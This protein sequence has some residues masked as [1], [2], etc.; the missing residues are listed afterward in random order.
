M[1][2]FEVPYNFKEGYVEEMLRNH[3][4]IK[5]IK[6]TYLP[7]WKD[8]ARTTR[9]EVLFKPWY[10]KTFDEYAERLK[11]LDE[12]GLKPCVLIQK[13]DHTLDLLQ[14]Y[15]DLGVR[16]FILNDDEAART[17]KK[18]HD[19]SLTLSITRVA[20][21]DELT[22][23]DF[24]MYDDIVLFFYYNR[25]LD[26]IKKLPRKYKYTIIV[27]EHCYYNCRLYKAHW[28][29]TGET[30]A[31]YK[32]N[33]DA[34]VKKCYELQQKPYR[35]G[36]DNDHYTTYIPPQALAVFDDYIDSYK[37]VDRNMPTYRIITELRRYAGYDNYYERTDE[38]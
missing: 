36:V 19:V 14:K 30:E 2:Q 23:H 10:P 12:A 1:H 37:L 18:D 3:D 38:S 6:C 31:E 24:S 33:N 34:V 20:K 9:G 15:Y 28:F 7:A 8:D 13:C 11:A 5:Y 4:L 16:R 35:D 17:F 26:L 27:N 29:V 25:H 32:K 21:F 22:T